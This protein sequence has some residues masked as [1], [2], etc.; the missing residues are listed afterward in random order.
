MHKVSHHIIVLKLFI[1][2]THTSHPH[3]T[4]PHTLTH[5]HTVLLT[6]LISLALNMTVVFQCI[7]YSKPSNDQKKTK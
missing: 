6:Y 1:I 4:H 3:T 7:I 5:P 2:T